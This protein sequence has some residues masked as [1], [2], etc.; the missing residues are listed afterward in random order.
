MRCLRVV[1]IAT[2][3]VSAGFAHAQQQTRN[4]IFGNQAGLT[5]TPT[6]MPYSPVATAFNTQE[7]SSTISDPAGNLLLY[8]D[9][10]QIWG[11]NNVISNGT[12][13]LGGSSATQSTLIVPWPDGKCDK[14][15]VFTVP[16]QED[17]SIST[18]ALRYS[19]VTFSGGTPSV[20]TTTKNV[21]LQQPVSEKL[22]AIADATGFWVVAHGFDPTT[23]KA[24]ANKEVYAFR[25]D[26]TGLTT[27]PVVSTGFVHFA[28]SN[29]S[30]N[31]VASAGQ[32]QIAP[33]GK[34]IACAVNTAF[35]E[36][37]G[38]DVTTGKVSP[39]TGVKLNADPAQPNNQF[40]S[41]R[42]TASPSRPT[43]SY[44][45]SRHS[46]GRA[47]SISLTR[48]LRTRRHSRSAPV[49]P[50]V[51]TTSAS[52]SSGTTIGSTSRAT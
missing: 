46:S 35:V 30:T 19:L 45:T 38:F 34:R 9:G 17:T 2:I 12:G 10:G 26:A 31:G 41:R 16:A 28:G 5:F 48:R 25:V 13:L 15:F 11:A 27:T 18:K 1:A 6:P 29:A 51:R 24:P 7:G 44:S 39:G 23:A 32:M 36:V 4:W 3:L 21:L 22:T 49:S 43:A 14:Y 8:T 37:W 50:A 42:F 40:S 20:S 52:C 47:A 33:D